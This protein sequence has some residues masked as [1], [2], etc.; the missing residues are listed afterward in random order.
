MTDT[1]TPPTRPSWRSRVVV[2][3][4]LAVASFALVVASVAGSLMVGSPAVAVEQESAV[5]V[6]W[7][8][9]NPA[10]VQRY[11]LDRE[12]K[13]DNADG[14][15]KWLDFKDFEVS[16][17]QTK[18]LRDQSLVVSFSGLGP[19]SRVQTRDRGGL[20]SF[21]Q[22]MQCW[23]PDP[24]AADFRETCQFGAS[25]TQAGY[26]NAGAKYLEFPVQLIDRGR[27]TTVVEGVERQGA[28]YRTPYGQVNKPQ[29][30]ATGNVI[31]N[32]IGTFFSADSSNELPLARL[33]DG[34]TTTRFE[35]Q[36]NTTGPY[37]GCGN[38]AAAGN[39]CWL[40]VVPRGSHSGTLE[41]AT[42]KC[43]PAIP[44][45][46]AGYTDEFGEESPYQEQSPLDS[47]CSYWDD[48]VV[49]PLDFEPTTASCPPGTS[50][51]RIDGSELSAALMTS[52]QENLCKQQ[53]GSVFS[54][55]TNP[56]STV[57]S[58]LLTGLSQ[59]ALVT[60]AV[61]EGEREEAQLDASQPLDV[62]Y[63]PVANTA[64]VVAF[65]ILDSSDTATT[66]LNLTPRLM[67]KLLTT[68]YEFQAPRL[69]GVDYV[70]PEHLKANPEH[71]EDDPEFQAANP[72]YRPQISGGSPLV[73]AG[74]HGDDAIRE[75]WRWIRSD[76]SAREW[77]QGMPDENGMV[78]NPYFLPATNPSA[79]D[80]AGLPFDLATDDIETIPRAD[81]TLAP[82]KE[83]AV[84]SY[85]G[86]QI[87]SQMMSPYASNFAGVARR[88]AT[89]TPGSMYSW[90]PYAVNSSGDAGAFV[91]DGRTVGKRFLL[92]ITD[93]A[94]ADR[95]GLE[96]A[97]LGVPNSDAFVAPDAAGISAGVGAGVADPVTGVVETDFAALGTTGYPLTQTLY[98]AVDLA[99]ADL[100][101]DGRAGY[102][103]MLDFAAGPGQSPGSLR[104]QLPTGYA[105][106]TQAQ[107]SAASELADLLRVPLPESPA[108]PDAPDA[109]VPDPA[110]VGGAAA[111]A[112]G[113]VA[114]PAAP[115]SAPAGTTSTVTTSAAASSPQ[116]TAAGAS[117]PVQG[118]LGA[119]LVAGL[120]G[121]V[122]AP[123]LL[124]RRTL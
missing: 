63:A 32:G 57:R 40:V 71:I 38:P 112:G 51:Q 103:Q 50:T 78:V 104:G 53:G 106:L 77:L 24:T 55:T 6:K 89:G 16:V 48:R 87:D 107:R 37:L 101:N 118:A 67:A 30:A 9:D 43:A 19:T 61:T 111:P 39:R 86:Q 94:T 46:E 99:N 25:S 83:L 117:S 29:A 76:D 11:Q 109:P 93:A 22:V 110:A 49:V 45:W 18:N 17:S 5:T 80:G 14:S 60:G 52:W 8:G 75:L 115:V 1:E 121:I 91:S 47:A 2:G 41:G 15:G 73:V 36:N 122:G 95:F 97:A 70:P 59:F 74:P 98:G 113:G 120:A 82:S 34:T 124:R 35:V 33:G 79:P 44:L 58:Q 10:E 69:S 90:Y 102:A 114:A 119:A 54:L 88:V 64:L 13:R 123:F 68:S 85:K 62:R 105:P 28:P 42:E 31:I 20:S 116:F 108:A 12:D 21:V 27:Q 66:Q 56:G 7:A 96:A 26:G 23:G 3:R 92:G 100:G 72:G 4:A 65:S 84:K 81:Q